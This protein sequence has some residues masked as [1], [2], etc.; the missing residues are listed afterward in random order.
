MISRDLVILRWIAII[1]DAKIGPGFDP[2][3]FG[4]LGW[5]PLRLL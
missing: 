4:R 1:E 3:E 2:E 5:M